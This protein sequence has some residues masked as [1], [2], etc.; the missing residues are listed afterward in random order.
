[1]TVLARTTSKFPVAVVVDWF[2]LSCRSS[3]VP[4]AGGALGGQPPL[5]PVQVWA[6]TVLA[7]F[8]AFG[9]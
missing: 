6:A 9:P 3:V 1:M 7:L 5:V 2:L 4:S 8:R